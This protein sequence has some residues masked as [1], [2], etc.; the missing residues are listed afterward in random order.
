M[1]VMVQVVVE[2]VGNWNCMQPHYRICEEM[3]VH[4][5]RVAVCPRLGE[6]DSNILHG[7]TDLNARKVVFQ[8]LHHAAPSGLVDRPEEIK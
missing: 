6:T 4:F 3:L 5:G 2:F 8:S 1:V 7:I